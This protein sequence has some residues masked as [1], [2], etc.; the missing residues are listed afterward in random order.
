MSCLGVD[1]SDGSS[2]AGADRNHT[3]VSGAYD[4]DLR[5]CSPRGSKV[6]VCACARACVN[7][8]GLTRPVPIASCCCCC[9]LVSCQ[10][11]ADV[12]ALFCCLQ[13]A[14]LFPALAQVWDLR[15]RACVVVL[16]QHD[17][18]ILSLDL[19]DGML[20]PPPLLFSMWRPGGFTIVRLRSS[21]CGVWRP[22]VFLCSVEIG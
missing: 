7:V 17:D 4:A 9:Q 15:Q 10:P 2:A 22:G 16:E 11:T 1:Y 8:F 18:P 3:I 6:C 14:P 20:G 13:C 19:V 21:G 12:C 5:V